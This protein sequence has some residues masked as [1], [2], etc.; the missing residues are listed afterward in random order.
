MGRRAT[1]QECA[2][3]ARRYTSRRAL[4][5]KNPRVY[6][7]IHRHGWHDLFNHM[8]PPKEI[9]FDEGS[10]EEKFVL[11]NYELMD[12]HSLAREMG[13]SIN[14]TNREVNRVLERHSLSRRAIGTRTRATR[15]AQIKKDRHLMMMRQ[16]GL[17]AREIGIRVGRTKTTVNKSF[18]RMRRN[19]QPGW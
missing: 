1:Y 7:A 16:D 10:A 13:Y 14:V 15:N 12:I 9:R 2:S 5:H 19:S 8:A 3:V 18:A 17:T 11:A 4:R 6:A